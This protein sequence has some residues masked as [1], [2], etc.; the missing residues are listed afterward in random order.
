MDDTTILPE[1]RLRPAGPCIQGSL[2]GRQPLGFNFFI[3]NYKNNSKKIYEKKNTVEC[4][5]V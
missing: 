1:L 5:I 4:F 3:R 2:N